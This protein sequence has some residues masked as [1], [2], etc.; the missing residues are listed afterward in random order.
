ML[1]ARVSINLL[2]GPLIIM[3]IIGLKSPVKS[4]FTALDAAST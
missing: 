1:V 3:L 2:I 4:N